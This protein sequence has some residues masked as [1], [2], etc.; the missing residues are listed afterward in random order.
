MVLDVDTFSGA[1]DADRALAARIGIA[2]VPA[3]VVGSG[4]DAEGVSGALPYA[5]LREMLEAKGRG[6]D[7]AA[8]GPG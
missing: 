7:P 8:A 4:A 3:L 2:A 6:A 1:V 5:A